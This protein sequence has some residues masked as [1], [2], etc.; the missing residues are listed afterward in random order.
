MGRGGIAY[1]GR[2]G[3]DQ[4]DH[5]PSFVRGGRGGTKHSQPPFFPFPAS[6]SMPSFYALA[7][8]VRGRWD[9]GEVVEDRNQLVGEEDKAGW[10]VVWMARDGLVWNYVAGFAKLG[11]MRFMDSNSDS[12]SVPDRTVE[13]ESEEGEAMCDNEMEEERVE[14]KGYMM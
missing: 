10:T 8:A 13:D 6:V 14:V 4:F 5:A 11:T 12:D 3:G 2:D 9:D 1:L 7:D